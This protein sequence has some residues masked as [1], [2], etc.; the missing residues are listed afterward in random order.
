MKHKSTVYGRRNP[1]KIGK[2]KHMLEK[3]EKEE[4]INDEYYYNDEDNFVETE[5]KDEEEK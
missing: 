3:L 2:R 4:H 1:S 5:K